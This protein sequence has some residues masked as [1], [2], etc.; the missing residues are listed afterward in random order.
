MNNDTRDPENKPEYAEMTDRHWR[1]VSESVRQTIIESLN[2]PVTVEAYLRFEKTF[3]AYRTVRERVMEMVRVLY[4]NTDRT[5][6][7]LIPGFIS[8]MKSTI[9]PLSRVIWENLDNRIQQ[10]KRERRETLE[11][12]L[13]K[14]VNSQEA[15]EIREDILDEIEKLD[16]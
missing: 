9:D 7:E 14:A 1:D 5:P 15:S 12:L 6:A 2:D 16:Q 4:P 8:K 10:L 3:Q 11:R 13:Q